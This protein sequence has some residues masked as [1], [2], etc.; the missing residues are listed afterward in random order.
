MRPRI[1]EETV[2][3]KMPSPPASAGVQERQERVN[4]CN[5][6][7]FTLHKAQTFTKCSN[8]KLECHQSCCNDKG[9][10]VSCTEAL[11]AC[12]VCEMGDATSI[13]DLCKNAV[14]SILTGKLCSAMGC[15][16]TCRGG[17]PSEVL[18]LVMGQQGRVLAFLIGFYFIFSCL[19]FQGRPNP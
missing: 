15:C 6:C 7:T 11:P 1:P 12:S 8:C 3:G 19:S 9:I 10:C 4:K 2:V 16:S 18:T 17:R 5:G 13:C 14:C